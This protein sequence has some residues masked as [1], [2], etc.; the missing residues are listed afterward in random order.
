MRPSEPR[1]SKIIGGANLL[2][3][4]PDEGAAQE[5]AQAERVAPI[6]NC[7]GENGQ[8]LDFL[9]VDSWAKCNCLRE[10]DIHIFTKLGKESLEG[11]LE[12]EGSVENF[13]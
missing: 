4:K 1:V 6:G 5:S 12:P 3:G 7:V 9:A 11:R 10:E 13:A 2:L 8:V